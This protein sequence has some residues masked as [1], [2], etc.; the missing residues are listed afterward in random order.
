M[1]LAGVEERDNPIN[2][3][4]FD[5]QYIYFILTSIFLKDENWKLSADSLTHIHFRSLKDTC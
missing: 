2:K 1:F 3:K 5:I 4:R